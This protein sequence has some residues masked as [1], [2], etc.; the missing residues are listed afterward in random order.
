[1]TDRL[2][3]HRDYYKKNREKL[4]QQSRE[5]HAKKRKYYAVKIGDN[6]YCFKYKQDIE[7]KVVGYDD[8]KDNKNYIR[9]F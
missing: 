1:M 3:Y 9:M 4:L 2:K 8:I 6:F 5:H 7:F